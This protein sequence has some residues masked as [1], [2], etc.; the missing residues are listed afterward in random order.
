MRLK[1]TFAVVTALLFAA[2][3]V[4]ARGQQIQFEP[5]AQIRLKTGSF[6]PGL[7]QQ[8]ALPDGFT[9]R[10]GRASG[11]RSYYLIQ[12]N[13]AVQQ[14]WKDKVVALG[15]DLLDYIPDNAFKVRM[16]ASVAA[17]VSQLGEIAYVGAFQPAYKVSPRIQ[18]GT[19][20]VYQVRIE[21]G[22]NAAAAAA[23]LNQ[24]GVQA[25]GVADGTLVVAA[26]AAGLQALAQIDDVAWIE[27]YALIEKHNEY[28]AQNII[29]AATVNA[30]GYDGSTQIAAVA[31]TGLGGGTAATAHADIPASRIVA[32]QNFPGVTDVC[33]QT[34]TND[35]AVDVDSGHGTHVAGS[36]LSDGDATGRGRGGA[37][38]ARLVFQAI[39]NYVTISTICRNQL[40]YQNDYYLTGLNNLSNVFQQAY[41]AGARVHANSW[42]SAAAGDYTD[43]SVTADT[44]IWNNR[45]MVITFSAGNEG[46]DANA[47]GV[48][49]NDSIGAPATAKNVITV[50]ASENDRGGNF[51]CDTS[52][53]YTS[54]DTTYQNGQTCNSMGGQNLLGTYGQ[55]WGADYPA[56]PIAS[57]LTGGNAQ[58]MAAFSSRGPTDDGRIKPD[59]VAPGTWILSTYSNQ[60]QEGYS[61]TVNPRNSAFQSDGWGMPVSTLYKYFGGTSMSNP[62]AAGGAVVIRDYYQKAHALNASAALVKATLINSAVDLL[63]ENNDGVNDNDFPIPNVHEGWGRIDLINATDGSAFFADNTAGLSTGGTVT[64]SFTTAG[65]QPFKV[66][67]VWSDYPSTAAAATN[68]VNNLNVTVTGPG[69]VTYRGNV[70]SGGWSQTGGTADSVNNV[71]NV[72]VQSAAAGTW[73]VTV[74]G[75]N[76]P[77]GPQPFAI[78]VEGGSAAPTPTATPVPPTA[79][80]TATPIPPTATPTPTPGGTAPAAPTSLTGTVLSTTSVRINWVDNANNETGYA[81]ERCTGQTCTNFTQ[82]ASVAANTTSF[83]NTGLTRNTYYRYRVRAFNSVGNSAYTNI[84]RLRPR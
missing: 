62:I 7:G 66:T 44:F 13:G 23:A 2:L 79:T 45:D 53:T 39:E 80:P 37:P 14:A 33:F 28:G 78:V 52:L 60:Y 64:Y 84:V 19:A 27:P 38:A 67:V 8:P 18:V 24:S 54:R 68:L 17:Q 1:A 76:V 82:I 50:G 77:Q 70:F 42:G 63:D 81:I 65:G 20:G 36:V 3:A 5:A 71:E 57:D 51:Q 16:S 83:T 55:R 48:V 46:I 73:T 34:I 69:G 41:N 58:Q 43:N 29:G 59:I 47:D 75:A 6:A 21:R 4:P 15:V 49:D 9:D 72:Y 26:D 31:D 40:G 10:A 25:M 74:N 35:G 12:F 11:A 30:N 61:T 22:G 32:I 56:N